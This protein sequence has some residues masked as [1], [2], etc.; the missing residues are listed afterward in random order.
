MTTLEDPQ[1]GTARRRVGLLGDVD[2]WLEAWTAAVTEAVAVLR[3]PAAA[4]QPSLLRSRGG[5][6]HHAPTRRADLH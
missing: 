4:G 5:G 6:E 2:R 3:W 1:G